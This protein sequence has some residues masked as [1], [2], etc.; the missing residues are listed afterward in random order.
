MLKFGLARAAIQWVCWTQPESPWKCWRQFNRF[1][2]S[3]D[4]SPAQFPQVVRW[5]IFPIIDFPLVTPPICLKKWNKV[6]S[7][8]KMRIVNKST[9]DLKRLAM[10]LSQDSIRINSFSLFFWI[11][12]RQMIWHGNVTMFTYASS[13]SHWNFF[14]FHLTLCRFL[15]LRF[16]MILKYCNEN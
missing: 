4:I 11:E 9:D 10:I 3:W 13:K 6:Y 15:L 16:Y 1:R 7:G 5:S 8:G 12:V 14:K 2:C